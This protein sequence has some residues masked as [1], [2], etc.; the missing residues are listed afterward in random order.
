MHQNYVQVRLQ[1][2]SNVSLESWRA[3][4]AW[5]VCFSLL[6]WRAI[7]LTICAGWETENARVDNLTNCCHFTAFLPGSN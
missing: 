2:V 3:K 5:H 1:L 4:K 6:T 7:F